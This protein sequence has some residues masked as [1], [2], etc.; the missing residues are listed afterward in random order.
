MQGDFHLKLNIQ[1]R[2]T[3]THLPP[4]QQ[5]PDSIYFLKPTPLR[6]DLPLFLFLPGMDGTGQLLRVQIPRLADAFDVRCLCIPKDDLSDW[7]T[8]ALQVVDLI[9]AERD[10]NPRREIYLCGESFGGCLALLVSILIPQ[11]FS[12]LILV[13]PASSFR[14]QPW[15][16]WSSLVTQWLPSWFYPSSVMGLLPILASLGRIEA[17]ERHAL[18]EAMNSLPQLTSAWRLDLLR[19]FK[20]SESQLRQID[21]PTLVIA[22]GADRLLPSV[23]EAKFLTK[24]LPNAE[25]VVLPNSGHACLLENEVDLYT[26]IQAYSLDSEAAKKK[27]PAVEVKT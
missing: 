23:L 17:P 6:S 13:N 18:L 16:R 10:A 14:Q 3:V 25:M 20:P 12:R 9:K 19:S 5:S 4:T 21:F 11:W 24:T 27:S 2:M 15:L 22:S 7:E 8:L 1:N 26:L